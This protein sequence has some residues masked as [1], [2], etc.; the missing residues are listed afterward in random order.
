MM[1]REET[2]LGDEEFIATN[3]IDGEH[4]RG[5]AWSLKALAL[6]EPAL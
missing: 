2:R 3:G 5:S 4:R 1:I 6:K